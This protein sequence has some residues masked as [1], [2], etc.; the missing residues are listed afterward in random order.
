MIKFNYSIKE[1]NPS[2][3]KMELFYYDKFIKCDELEDTYFYD[4]DA[5]KFMHASGMIG[6]A[7]IRINY[8]GKLVN[9]IIHDKGFED[10]PPFVKL[11]ILC[12]ELGHIVYGHLNKDK[13]KKALLRIADL[14]PDIEAEADSYAVSRLGKEETKKAIMFLIKETDMPISAKYEFTRRYHKIK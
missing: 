11:F 5:S 2:L 14:F 4:A 6:G 8:R 3:A 12:H 7:V 9:L 10:C 13:S 1:Y